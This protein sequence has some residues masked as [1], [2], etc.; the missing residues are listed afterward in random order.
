MEYQ[1]E[2]GKL[3]D[4]HYDII[5]LYR[6]KIMLDIILSHK[7]IAIGATLNALESRAQP[8][9]RRNQPRNKRMEVRT[10]FTA[11]DTKSILR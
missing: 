10:P 3:D 6:L 7:N 9:V 8:P 2:G 11:A 1:N 5:K 4:W